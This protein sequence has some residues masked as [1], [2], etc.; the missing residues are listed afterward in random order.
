MTPDA[1]YFTNK[2][3]EMLAFIPNQRNKV[4]EIGCAQGEFLSALPGVEERWGI[5]PSP[6]ALIAQTRL[7]KVFETTFDGAQP[8]LPP[9]Y[10]D[11]VICNDVIEHMPDHDAFFAKIGAHIAPGG[12]IVG[13]IPN[14]RFYK[15]M[16]EFIVEKDWH[17]TES[18]ILDRTHTRF[19]TQKSFQ[20]CLSRHGFTL[21]QFAGLN[22]AGTP[23]SGRPLVYYVASRAL[24]GLTLGYFNDIKYL[25]FGFR[26]RPPAS[27]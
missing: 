22:N 7:T 23:R 12:V 1:S 13:S 3:P 26:A 17:Y 10:F 2:R 6:A 24:I 5:E 25:Q 15:N 16:F 19:F 14:V 11:V 9:H 27:A 8:N 18:G 20:K 4:L 21:D